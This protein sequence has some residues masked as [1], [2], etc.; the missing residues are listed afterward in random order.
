[1]LEFKFP[2]QKY[3]FLKWA[4]FFTLYTIIST[5]SMKYTVFSNGHATIWPADAL[6]LAAIFSKKIKDIKE[7]TAITFFANTFSQFI[8]GYHHFYIILYAL[9]SSLQIFLSNKSYIKNVGNNHIFSQYKYIV[10]FNLNSGIVFPF[11]CAL[12]GTFFNTL[13][14][15]TL[16][17]DDFAAWFFALSLGNV[18]FTRP[19]TYIL[20][21]TFFENLKKLTQINPLHALSI[22]LS[23]SLTICAAFYVFNQSK[24]PFLFVPT[25]LVIAN[26]LI[27]G[28]IFGSITVMIIAVI[29][30]QAAF[31]NLGPIMLMQI[32]ALGRQAVL[33]TYLLFTV[34]T[35]RA[36]SVLFMRNKSLA[37]SVSAREQM[38]ALV[39][40]NSTDCIININHEGL[41]LW[42][43]G[44]A[45]DLLGYSNQDIIGKNLS[46]I[47]NINPNNQNVIKEF[48]G[49]HDEKLE[50]ISVNP[51]FNTSLALNLDLRKFISDGV[52]AGAIA[53]LNDITEEHEKL[54][55]AV[56]KSEKDP[57]T[58]LLNRYGFKEKMKDV[59]RLRDDNLCISYLDIDHFKEIND[60][61]SHEAGD[62]ILT[63]LANLMQNAIPSPNIVSR[64]GGDEFVIALLE[65]DETS[66]DL[67]HS[68]VEKISTTVFPLTDTVKA[69]ITISCGFSF[70][71]PE[72]TLDIVIQEADSALYN[73]KQTGRNRLCEFAPKHNISAA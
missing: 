12:L 18:T 9:I 19:L 27:T 34:F 3:N 11:I 26:S 66:R 14:S 57:L 41:C 22:I 52:V 5:I 58:Q 69:K 38:L 7:A 60:T 33:Q 20:D 43:G 47:I 48:F 50:S 45:L 39:L 16:S 42:A 31:S 68:L 67:L 32:G 40:V 73:A 36:V 46:D 35:E 49:S 21:G 8:C 24:Y 2:N 30:T 51:R 63:E 13:A 44:A 29:A 61:Y 17:L 37:Q 72:K 62:R 28:E 70:Y 53:T 55:V 56:E 54:A 25:S 65:T 64:F 59:L 71:K 23:L 15:G 1:M 10:K 4:L 6:M